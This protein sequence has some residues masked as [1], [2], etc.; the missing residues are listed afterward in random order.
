MPNFFRGAGGK[1]GQNGKKPVFP[2]LLASPSPSSQ[3]WAKLVLALSWTI[4]NFVFIAY[5][6]KK[7]KSY[8]G[9]VF[10]RGRPDPP[11]SLVLE[12]LILDV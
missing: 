4:Q 11:S 5:P 12:G 1:I 6:N 8:G 7:I 10:K 9:K 3:L 2:L